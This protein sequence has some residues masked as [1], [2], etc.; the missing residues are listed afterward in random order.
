MGYIYDDK[1]GD[2]KPTGATRQTYQSSSSSSHRYQPS[3]SGGCFDGCLSY[4][5]IFVV[6]SL[7]MY[8]CS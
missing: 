7:L 2:F 4:I 8:L 3:T 5:I 1:T 6:L